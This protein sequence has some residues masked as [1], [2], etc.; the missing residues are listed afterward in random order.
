M[1]LGLHLLF[2]Y[3]ILLQIMSI[4]Y[5][6]ASTDSE[7]QQIITLQ[8][9]NLPVTISENEM[10]KEGFVT[11]KHDIELLTKMNQK[12]PHIIAKKEDAVV[13]YALCMIKEFKNDIDV[14][15]PMFDK[16]D[17]ELPDNGSY[18]VMGQ[19]CVDKSFRKQGIF[20]GLYHKMRD[21]LQ[22]TYDFLITEVAAKNQRSLHAHYAIGFKDLLVYTTEDNITWHLIQWDWS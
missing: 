6:T 10:K 12:Q 1:E 8:T 14:L 15:K 22:S 4:K 7:L 17:N 21:E 5:T 2:L 9:L 13:G 18:I 3:T 16:I 11:V 20:R 19:V